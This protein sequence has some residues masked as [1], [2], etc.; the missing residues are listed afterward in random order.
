MSHTET[1][2]LGSIGRI[3]TG[4]TPS[5]AIDGAFGG[6]VPFITPSDMDGRKWIE[7]TERYLTSAGVN[8]VKNSVL[9]KNSIAVS[10]I[11]SDMGKVVMV[12]RNSV[13][14]QQI[15][16]IIVD[17]E[18]Y[19]PEYIYY[20]LLP[21]QKELKDLASGSATPILSKGLFSKVTADVVP[22]PTQ[23]AIVEILSSLDEK[24]ELNRKQNRTLEAIAQ[25]LFK[26]WFVDFEFPDEN[27][28]AYK[29]SGGTMQPSELGE[30]PV[31]WQT[32]RL[33]D[34]IVLQ[35][36]FDL[37]QTKR[38]PG[39][40]PVL[41]A[42]GKNG[43]HDEFKVKG[44]G[45]T[46][47]RSGVIGRVF[48]VHE[49]FWPLNTSLW[50]KEFKKAKPA[51]AY[52]LLMSLDFEGFKAGS[53]VPTLNRN[54]VHSLDMV[55]PSMELIDKFEEMASSLLARQK[56]NTEQIDTLSA[57]RD[58]LLPKLMSGEIRVA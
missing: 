11:G 21:R 32:G 12:A 28:R 53:A 33:D 6:D 52:F 46:T 58:T 8:A 19:A 38:T 3:V 51:Y 23:L 16:S 25:A 22:L 35:R 9:P 45:V 49:D 34:V 54:H 5:S 4:K 42:S 40:Y 18:R 13:S 27:G 31:D 2:E 39:P 43:S 44:P 56:C 26:H 1:I 20:L 24:I 36:G 17:E 30:I 14:N 10:C 29:S 48:Y 55:I 7:T 50:V 47:G 41:A 15:N 37:P 57:L